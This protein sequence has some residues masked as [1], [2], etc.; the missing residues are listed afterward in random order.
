MFPPNLI[1]AQSAFSSA[2]VSSVSLLTVESTANADIGAS[3]STM[4]SV[5]SAVSSF[6]LNALFFIVL[7]P[8]LKFLSAFGA[9]NTVL[10]NIGT[11]VRAFST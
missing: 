4:H 9:E 3:D 5:S 10:F 1:S 6:V 11:A 2:A 7:F 8:F